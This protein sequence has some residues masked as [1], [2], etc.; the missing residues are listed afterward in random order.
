MKP[1]LAGAHSFLGTVLE[2]LNDF[3]AAQ[4]HLREALR[5]DPGLAGAHAQLATLLRGKLPEADLDALRQLAANPDLSGSKRSSLHFGLAL[6]L[7]AQSSYDEAAGHLRQANALRLADW[8]TQGMDYD[9]AAHAQYV[10]D[11]VATCTPAFFERVRGFGLET[12]QPVFIVGLPRSGTTLTE[13]V[14][15]SHSQVFGAGE[16][17]LASE[18]FGSLPAAMNSEAPAV[19]CLGQLDRE[20]AQRLAERHLERLRTQDEQRCASPTRCRTTI[21]SW[22]CWRRSSRGPGSST[23]GATCATLPSPAG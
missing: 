12:E 13:Q 20:A 21:S 19:K 4:R 9:P 2:E 7:D 3:E 22:A 18:T 16:L 10:E 14:L 1:D 8:R 17:N 23:A 11:L 6:V 5:L 15:A